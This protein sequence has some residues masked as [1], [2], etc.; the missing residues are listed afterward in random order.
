MNLTMQYNDRTRAF[1]VRVPRS[2]AILVQSLMSEHGL[3]FSEPASSSSEA[4]LFT[5]E[6]YAAAAFYDEGDARAKA[7]LEPI[8]QE[9]AASWRTEDGGHYDVPY[10]KELWPF[11]RANLAYALRRRAT[12]IGDE[13]GLGKTPT[14]IAFCNETRAK[15]VLVICPASIR[16]QWARR[17]YEWSTISDIRRRGVYTV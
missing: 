3:D 8:I 16:L 14:A 17:I 12:L 5:F 2:E 11:Q 4:V 9:C 6:P 15:R 7:M 1:I 10:G 13:P